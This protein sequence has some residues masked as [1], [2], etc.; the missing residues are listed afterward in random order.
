MTAVDGLIE[1][2]RLHRSTLFSIVV[3]LRAI[4]LESSHMI[5]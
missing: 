1:D 5:T 4:A 2:L 3:R